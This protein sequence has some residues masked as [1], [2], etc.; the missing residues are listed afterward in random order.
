MI[1]TTR[2]LKVREDVPSFERPSFSQEG[3]VP[4]VEKD[5][6]RTIETLP[7]LK[8]I[9]GSQRY[10]PGDHS[11]IDEFR[12]WLDTEDPSSTLA[13]VGHGN[14][15]KEWLSKD[16]G[17]GTSPRDRIQT[18]NVDA[19][20]LFYVTGSGSKGKLG[21]LF[22]AERMVLNEAGEV[23][24]QDLPELGH[25]HRPDGWV[26]SMPGGTYFKSAR[27]N[28]SLEERQW[29]MFDAGLLDPRRA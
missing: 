24:F 16:L 7:A 15:L 17:A 10:E 11:R 21:R 29:L 8:E 3:L 27:M 19:F 25:G 14:F 20:R 13:V 12:N 5:E 4:F 23:E 22:F 9:H 26:R 18:Q 28:L 2:R 1:L 6:R